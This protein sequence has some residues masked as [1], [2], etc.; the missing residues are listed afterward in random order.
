MW[1]PETHNRVHITATAPRMSK[2]SRVLLGQEVGNSVFLTSAKAYPLKYIG[3]VIVRDLIVCNNIFVTNEKHRD[4][5]H[6]D[7]RTYAT[8]D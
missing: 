3:M 5:I 7:D 4:G 2:F 6:Y 1:N 8:S